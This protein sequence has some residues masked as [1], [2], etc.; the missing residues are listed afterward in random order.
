MKDTDEVYVY[1][2]PNWV[3]GIAVAVGFGPLILVQGYAVYVLWDFDKVRQALLSLAV[4]GEA[5]LCGW[6]L[7]R[8]RTTIRFSPDEVLWPL[9]FKLRRE[10]VEYYK[11]VR[12]FGMEWVHIQR[13]RG[14]TYRPILNFPG[15]REFRQRLLE[16]LG[17]CESA[18]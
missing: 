18:R 4:V 14:V 12:R 16:W 17:R 2:S 5:G 6:W 7:S 15:G 11:I 1:R 9:G 3:V 8:T 13:K 10:D